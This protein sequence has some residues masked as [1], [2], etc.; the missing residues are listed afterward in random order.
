MKFGDKKYVQPKPRISSCT[1]RDKIDFSIGVKI[2]LNPSLSQYKLVSDCPICFISHK[3]TCLWFLDRKSEYSQMKN[4][5]SGVGLS[6][7]QKHT[8]Y[9]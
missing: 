9:P 8:I 6:L 3:S 2:F 4:V 5:F 7:F 1:T